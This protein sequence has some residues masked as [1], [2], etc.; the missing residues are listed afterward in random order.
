MATTVHDGD[1]STGHQL[2]ECEAQSSRT[3]PGDEQGRYRRIGGVRCGC[4]CVVGADGVILP[5]RKPL[6][7][8]DGRVVV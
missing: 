8:E 4:E 6:V 7:E 3:G 2:C 5:K 1:V